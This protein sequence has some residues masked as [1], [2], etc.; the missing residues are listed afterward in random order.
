MKERKPFGYWTYERCKETALKY[1]SFINFRRDYDTIHR[2]IK[3][4]GWVELISHLKMPQV[5]QRGYWSYE[6][7][8]ETAL[9]YEFLTDFKRENN[10]GYRAVKRHNWCELISHLKITHFK[11]VE[12]KRI[13]YAYEFV[14]TKTVYV[15]LTYNLKNRNLKH[16]RCRHSSVYKYIKKYGHKPIL[17]KLTDYIDEKSSGLIEEYFVNEYKEN[18]WVILNKVKTGGL[19]GG[20]NVWSKEYITELIKNCSSRSEMRGILNNWVIRVMK[21]NNWWDELTS[22]LVNDD[23]VQYWTDEK[24]KEYVTVFKNKTELYNKMGGLRKYLKRNPHLYSLFEKHW[25]EIDKN[26]FYYKNYTD[27]MF[28]KICVEYKK[29]SELKTKRGGLYKFFLKNDLLNKYFPK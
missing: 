14:E 10:S 29:R 26:I 18:D 17:K 11:T 1:E 8:K 9:K 6:R 20:N 23:L 2:K 19:G 24:A 7:C 16:L 4:Y 12:L 27:E 28:V 22:H 15:G 13:I 25:E 5:K 21:K 3:K